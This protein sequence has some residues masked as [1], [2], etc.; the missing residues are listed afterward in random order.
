MPI[1][2][3]RQVVKVFKRYVP[4]VTPAQLYLTTLRHVHFLGPGLV[5]SVAY[6]DPGNWATD[7]KAGANYGY[8]LLFIILLAGLAAAGIFASYLVRHG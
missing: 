2:S 7:I 5:S 1:P 8:K 3:P 4:P 6:I